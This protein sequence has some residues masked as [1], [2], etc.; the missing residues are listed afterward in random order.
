M[1]PLPPDEILCLGHPVGHTNQRKSPDHWCE[2]YK[3][4]ARHQSISLAPFDSG[5][6]VVRR[7]CAAGQF[8]AYVPVD[9]SEP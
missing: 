8:D 7:H 3:T 2:K 1:I 9:R 6:K 5:H 4:C